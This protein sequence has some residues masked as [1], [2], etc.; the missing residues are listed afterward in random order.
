MDGDL[1]V[2][3]HYGACTNCAILAH[4]GSVLFI[5]TTTAITTPSPAEAL[6]NT[7]R[8]SLARGQHCN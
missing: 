2:V 7:D 5:M 4:N 3:G 6:T 1:D 8:L